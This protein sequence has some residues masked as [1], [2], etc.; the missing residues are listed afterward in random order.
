MNPSQKQEQKQKQRAAA[1]TARDENDSERSLV[2]SSFEDEGV[3][4][5][6]LEVGWDANVDQIVVWYYDKLA[7][8]HTEEELDLC[9]Y[10]SVREVEQ[11]IASSMSY[12]G[13]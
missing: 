11:W 2:G 5:K 9:E 8:T 6:V 7:N 3:E 13:E 1:P 10:S 4:W 12:A